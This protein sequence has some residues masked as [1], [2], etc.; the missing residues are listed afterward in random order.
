MAEFARLFAPNGAL[1]IF[2]NQNLATYAD[3]SGKEWKWK[4]DSP[5]GQKLSAAT[6]K[7]FQR[8]A[9]IRQ[10]FFPLGG[11]RPSLDI[12][13]SQNSLHDKVKSAVLEV[14]GQVIATQPAGNTPQ[15][16]NWPGSASSGSASI[17]LSPQ[18]KGR[19]NAMQLNGAWAF[20]RLLDAGTPKLSGDVIQTRYTI[21]GR[22]IGYD[23]RVSDSDLNPFY[24]RALNEFK[25]PSG[26]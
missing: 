16:I 21:G 10:A 25:C 6:L 11:G 5:M 8:A 19:E 23:F 20:M 3:L 14:N 26:L 1:D 15:T 9:E 4:Q 2:F 13:I 17:Q 24:L 18:M 7:Q 12:T 22:Y